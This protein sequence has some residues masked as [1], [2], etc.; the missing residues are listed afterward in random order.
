MKC[1]LLVLVWQ[2]DPERSLNGRLFGRSPEVSFT[3]T[4]QQVKN[5]MTV[6]AMSYHTFSEHSELL[7]LPICAVVRNPCSIIHTVCYRHHNRSV[8]YIHD[9]LHESC[10][11]HLFIC[12][13][14]QKQNS[15]STNKFTN[16]VSLLC[17]PG[18]LQTAIWLFGLSKLLFQ[19]YANLL[20]LI[21]I[22]LHSNRHRQFTFML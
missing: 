13:H 10:A 14:L 20:K 19:Q 6:R 7:M 9:S 3:D 5:T 8:F 16:R 17:I 15:A 18:G 11:L 12:F 2:A 4:L 21:Y 22:H 1:R